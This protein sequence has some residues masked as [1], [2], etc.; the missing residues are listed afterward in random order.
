MSLL[1]SLL[2]K[3]ID[4]SNFTSAARPQHKG[5]VFG[6]GQLLGSEQDGGN[7]FAKLLEGHRTRGLTQARKGDLDI[8]KA[9]N[10]VPILQTP[11]DR[12]ATSIRSAK[13]GLFDF[14]TEDEGV[15]IL[16]H[17]Y[18]DLMTQPNDVLSGSD[19]MWIITIY[20]ETV[21]QNYLFIERDELLVPQKLWV[22][23]PHW[24]TRLPET[25]NPFYRVKIGNKEDAIFAGDM[26]VI[27]RPNPI[28]PYTKGIGKASAVEDEYVTD[29]M[30][31]KWNRQ[32]FTNSAR[33]DLLIYG[34]DLGPEETKDLEEKWIE[35]NRGTSK[36]F[37]PFFL[38]AQIEVR[39]LARTHTDMDFSN[40]RSDNKHL[41]R[42]NWNVPP[43]LTGDL[44]GSNKATIEG[45]ELI[46]S[47]YVILPRLLVLQEKFNHFLSVEYEQESLM[48]IYENIV[49]ED[50]EFNLKVAN[51][52]IKLGT[53]TVNQW[54]IMTEQEPLEQGGDVFYLNFST[55]PVENP[56][57]LAGGGLLDT[58]PVED[59][60][61]LSVKE[62]KALALKN[63]G[64]KR[65]PKPIKHSRNG[66]NG[67]SKALKSETTTLI[68]QEKIPQAKLDKILALETAQFE[69]LT[70]MAIPFIFESIKRG[71]KL[72]NIGINFT[73]TH[74][75]VIHFINQTSRQ[76][77][78]LYFG[79][80]WKRVTANITESFNE[81]L[82]IP[83]LA[84]KLKITR[85]VNKV[86]S[87]AT[88]RTE[89]INAAN[90]GRNLAMTESG[91]RQKEWLTAR[92]EKVRDE[93]FSHVS[94]DGQ[95]VKVNDPFSVSGE[96][97][98]H[99]ADSSLGASAGNTINCR[100]TILPVSNFRGSI[101]AR[102]IIWKGFV[103]EMLPVER[104]FLKGLKRYYDD[105][106]KTIMK[107]LES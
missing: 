27:N 96:D 74:P 10:E 29:E 84:E 20:Y 79:S 45:S 18:I 5:I 93:E 76:R 62:R 34:A 15:E 67:H 54:R 94:A 78:P 35:R 75:A 26:F 48:H 31:S 81:G 25:G 83:Q 90:G 57:D 44:T 64:K 59:S 52:G 40:L 7:F 85:N 53:M 106:F 50:K 66:M 37:K 21:G 43:E 100:C 17:P 86:R 97:I 98:M 102:D 30:A 105:Q 60:I 56:S 68:P 2:P 71:T 82:T 36:Q 49:P 9:F 107:I 88:A 72:L 73:E 22:F 69:K 23:P 24:I 28:N 80:S 70:K 51:A 63:Q 11:I 46:Y 8:L 99:P 38:N 55:I 14:S 87:V 3:S 33:P 104:A 61:V 77:M 65:L 6:Q 19:M 12:I 92:D 47:K 95:V 41:T 58:E 103:Q 91:I 4:L 89:V 42:E 1:T 32:F 16:D 101:T 13:W 39:E